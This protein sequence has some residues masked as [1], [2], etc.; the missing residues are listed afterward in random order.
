MNIRPL[1]YY[2][3]IYILICVYSYLSLYSNSIIVQDVGQGDSIYI[4]Y[5]STSILID[6][7][8]SEHTYFDIKAVNSPNCHISYV[9]LTHPHFDHYRGLSRIFSRCY[10]DNFVYIEPVTSSVEFQKFIEEFLKHTQ[11][12]FSPVPVKGYF[13]VVSS[14]SLISSFSISSYSAPLIPYSLR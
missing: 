6:G 7:G 10:V 5:D 11:G 4:N 1:I 9:F 13:F 2:I 8:P 12:I 14:A 3:V